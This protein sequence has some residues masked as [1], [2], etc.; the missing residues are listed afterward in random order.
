MLAIA[1]LVNRP[2]QSDVPDTPVKE[3]SASLIV[4]NTSR[5]KGTA[6]HNAGSISGTNHPN[7][8]KPFEVSGK[9]DRCA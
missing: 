5:F 4:I 9:K 8:S 7:F 3:L 6:A 2:P 1:S